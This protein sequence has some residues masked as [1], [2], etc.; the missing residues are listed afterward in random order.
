M[1]V[2]TSKVGSRELEMVKTGFSFWEQRSRLGSQGNHIAIYLVSCGQYDSVIGY[3]HGTNH[4]PRIILI[5][6]FENCYSQPHKTQQ[7]INTL[8]SASPSHFHLSHNSHPL[9]RQDTILSN[10]LSEITTTTSFAMGGFK[11]EGYNYST[12]HSDQHDHQQK[13]HD[14]DDS[15]SEQLP[16]AQQDT[17]QKQLGKSNTCTH[18]NPSSASSIFVALS[19]P[20]RHSYRR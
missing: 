3:I 17:H 1:L 12:R 20:P 15:S 19:L 9:Q 6:L 4:K 8:P 2:T 13:S 18:T 5:V 11:P 16:G 14:T 7:S 10:Q